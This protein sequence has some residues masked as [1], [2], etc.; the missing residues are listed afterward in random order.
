M[1]KF[2]DIIKNKNAI[3]ENST[4]DMD[5]IKIY[6]NNRINTL[7]ESK[8][9]NSRMQRVLQD[10]GDLELGIQSIIENHIKQYEHL[11][12]EDILNSFDR[13]TETL[14]ENRIR[15][16]KCFEGYIKIIQEDFASQFNIN[17]K[18][19]ECWGINP[20]MLIEKLYDYGT[21]IGS[22]IDVQGT[23]SEKFDY[24]SKVLFESL[25][26]EP[27]NILH[28]CESV[29][30][31]ISFVTSFDKKTKNIERLVH[32]NENLAN[33]YNIYHEGIELIETHENNALEYF[34]LF[35]NSEK[36]LYDFQVQ[37]LIKTLKNPATFC[38]IAINWVHKWVLLH[39]VR[40]S[41]KFTGNEF[42]RLNNMIKIF[43]KQH[44]IFVEIPGINE[45]YS[46][47]KLLEMM[48]VLL[49]VSQMLRMDLRNLVLS[50]MNLVRPMITSYRDD[51][52]MSYYNP[53]HRQ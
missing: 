45:E 22:K 1:K 33:I 24:Q 26:D 40:L 52:Q 19:Q 28:I 18:I 29:M 7:Y 53:H 4:N 8:E 35:I 42:I 25:P 43:E 41:Y 21:V 49:S 11:S 10:C 30:D 32:L 17:Q 31:S 6:C 15:F 44:P 14:T 12:N 50:Y 13:K 36:T 16:D 9:L 23:L 38:E 51:L 20:D 5:M 37:H 27:K 34:Q 2:S 3:L 46:I 39:Q 47:I 48:D